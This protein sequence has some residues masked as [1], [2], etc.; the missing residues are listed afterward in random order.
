V[1]LVAFGSGWQCAWRAGRRRRLLITAV[2][3]AVAIAVPSAASVAR[4]LQVLPLSPESAQTLRVGG[5]LAVAAWLAWLAADLATQRE[6]RRGAVL[7]LLVPALLAAALVVL[8]GRPLAQNW[9]EWQSTL[10]AGH[11]IARQEF[12][13]PTAP[14]P[15]SAAELKLDL[16][17]GAM[18]ESDVVVRVNDLEVKRYRGGPTRADA[19]LPAQDYYQQVFDA[20][21]HTV[22]P[23]RAWYSIP[24]AGDLIAPGSR[25]A[26]EVAVEG[27]GEASGSLVLFGDYA[28]GATSYVGPSL[29]APALK[30]DRSLYKYLVDDDFRMRRTFQLSGAS[31]SRFDDGSGW[32]ERD[33]AVDAGRQ[34][35]RYRIFLLLTYDRG[36][37]IL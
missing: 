3:T 17:P 14:G 31:P 4:L 37:A 8:A 6:G 18:R 36:I 28:P 21:G 1:A 25:L 32:S 10:Q 19:D 24:I 26:V 20:R 34:Q 7:A 30:A 9:R 23:D 35:G 16:L 13:V 2:V 5:L 33:L 29:F 12:T 27:G 11:G 22:E 15:P